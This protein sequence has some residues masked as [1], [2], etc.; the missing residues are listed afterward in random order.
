LNSAAGQILQDDY[1]AFSRQAKLM[2]SIHAQIPAEM[3]AAVTEARRR[4]DEGNKDIP[5]KQPNRPAGPRT[6]SSSSSVVMKK[7]AEPPR[8]TLT[9]STSG[10]ALTTVG[11]GT[12]SS[13]RRNGL[14]PSVLTHDEEESEEEDAA[15]ASKENNPSLSPS[16][17]SPAPPSPQRNI[18]GKRPLSALPTPID[19]DLTDEEAD[20]DDLLSPSERNVANNLTQTPQPSQQSNGPA[21]KSPK[22]SELCKGVNVNASGRI[23]DDVQIYE[24]SNTGE[25]KENLGSGGEKAHGMKKVVS[26]TAPAVAPKPSAARKV[27]TA[28]AGNGKGKARAGLRRL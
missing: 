17:V 1:E 23:R 24:D 18:L 20:E 12:L 26:G 22:L 7:R 16:P 9:N 2:T 4:G 21:R 28:S 15:T 6:T 13:R 8:L 10:S 14:Q 3:K 5:E 11:V 25:G 19:P 27:S